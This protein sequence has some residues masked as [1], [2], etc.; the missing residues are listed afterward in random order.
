MKKG[1]L[2]V[3]MFCFIIIS[4]DKN[5]LYQEIKPSVF[6]V[7][8]RESN[9]FDYVKS[10]RIENGT[11]K[12][13]N[14]LIFPSWDKYFETIDKLD[15][16]VDIECDKFDATILRNEYRENKTKSSA[17][18]ISDDEYDVLADLAGFDEDNAL[19]E[20]EEDL[21][22]KSL[23][24]KIA[25][26][27]DNWLAE[28]GDDKWD[29]NFDPDNHFIDDETER[30]L[31]SENAEVVIGDDEIGYV[32]YKLL[33]DYGG[34]IQVY[35]SDLEAINQV[36]NGFVPIK[37]R[38]VVI[39]ASSSIMNTA[40]DCKRDLKEVEYEIFGSQRIKRKSKVRN[41]DWWSHKKVSAM[42]IGYKKKNGKWKRGR[43]N[44]TAGITD[45][46]GSS[47]GFVYNNCS[48]KFEIMEI[49][50]KHRRRV[51]VKVRGD[52]YNGGDLIIGIKDNNIYSFH[53]QNG[54]N[55]KKDYY[56]MQNY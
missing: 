54:L 55:V 46:S 25:V 30:A 9:I 8:K 13:N 48:T 29:S 45:I 7:S 11:S 23:R 15:D 20:F 17:L 16:M 34:M 44:I 31:L 12:G 10:F 26:E 52:R 49:K 19:L 37:N 56:D 24:R 4:C 38:N 18:S 42:T 32:Y 47:A 53:K 51:K 43:T 14:V 5:E 27:E 1:I 3:I 22:F 21:D 40:V 39:V 36:S 35:N 2:S 33:D 6:N 28:Q 50:E 41:N